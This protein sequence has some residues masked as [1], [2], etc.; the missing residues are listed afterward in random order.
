MVCVFWEL[1]AN[2]AE[3]VDVEAKPM[4]VKI[5]VEAAMVNEPKKEFNLIGKILA[6]NLIE[7]LTI[8]SGLLFL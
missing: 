2:L 4:K 6:P 3:K 8:I 1:V 5:I 7:V